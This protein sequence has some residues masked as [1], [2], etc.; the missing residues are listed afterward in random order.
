LLHRCLFC[1]SSPLDLPKTEVVQ[2][3][4]E[5]MRQLTHSSLA[6]STVAEALAAEATAPPRGLT[7]PTSLV[8]G[9]RVLQPTKSSSIAF[10]SLYQAF[11]A[12]RCILRLIDG[13]DVE[14]FLAT[15]DAELQAARNGLVEPEL[16]PPRRVATTLLLRLHHSETRELAFHFIDA[17]AVVASS[18]DDALP[19]THEVRMTVLV[20]G[21]AA[22]YAKRYGIEEAY[23]SSTA[24]IATRIATSLEVKTSSLPLITYTHTMISSIQGVLLDHT[25]G[26]C[27]A[28]RTFS[29]RLNVPANAWA[30]AI[31][32]AVVLLSNL[33]KGPPS[34]TRSNKVLSNRIV[35]KEIGWVRVVPRDQDENSLAAFH[36]VLL[37]SDDT[38]LNADEITVNLTNMETMH[39]H[40]AAVQTTRV[41]VPNVCGYLPSATQLVPAIHRHDAAIVPIECVLSGFRVLCCSRQLILPINERLHAPFLEGIDIL[42]PLLRRLSFSASPTLSTT[43]ET[44]I[45]NF[46]RLHLD[47]AP[48]SAEDEHVL[49]LFGIQIV[50]EQALLGDLYAQLL[51]RNAPASI[52]G[53]VQRLC[54]TVGLN[55]TVA[56]A[57]VRARVRLD[58]FETPEAQKMQ[59]DAIARERR[60]TEAALRVGAKRQ[61]TMPSPTEKMAVNKPNSSSLEKDET[62]EVLHTEG[63]GL[64]ITAQSQGEII[65]KKRL[66]AMFTLLQVK[67]LKT[68]TVHLQ[69]PRAENFS[70]IVTLIT[71]DVS[72]SSNEDSALHTRACETARR[73]SVQGARAVLCTLLLL[74]EAPPH[75]VFASTNTDAFET[76]HVQI[77]DG[78]AIQP[79]TVREGVG[80]NLPMMLVKCEPRSLVVAVV[81]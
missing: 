65:T 7:L 63:S 64:A 16:L 55:C 15:E 14:R 28:P 31:S 10:H 35:L 79:H 52:V 54:L 49:A 23:K 11:L 78:T 9:R 53:F 56:D 21:D 5:T 45:S 25:Q 40:T 26:I 43:T 29:T 74:F 39:L 68:A 73:V 61:R 34:L 19:V 70:S 60:I 71:M 27:L 76:I 1:Q 22:A 57:F 48:P 58:G 69:D 30:T 33:R 2:T 47:I 44:T 20:N 18:F 67:M 72:K 24:T 75:V 50:T 41:H 12:S 42:S 32:E 37:G 6:I 46:R 62:V 38:A 3:G 36:G 59:S 13:E 51:S 81:G 66:N 17:F 8:R 77:W 4:G 80:G